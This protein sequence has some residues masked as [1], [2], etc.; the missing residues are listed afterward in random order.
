MRSLKLRADDK[1]LLGFAN[2]CNSV[3]DHI[4]GSNKHD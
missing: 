2:E 1:C 4:Q 3:N